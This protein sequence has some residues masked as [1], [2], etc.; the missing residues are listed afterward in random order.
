[1]SSTAT[2]LCAVPTLLLKSVRA[3]ARAKM[4]LQHLYVTTGTLGTLGGGV[5]AYRTHRV[6][7]EAPSELWQWLYCGCTF[8]PVSIHFSDSIS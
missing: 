7:E 1:M 8:I 5:V 6:F 3:R 2:V 4:A